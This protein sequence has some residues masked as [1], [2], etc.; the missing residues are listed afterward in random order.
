MTYRCS[1]AIRSCNI[2]RAVEMA[3]V[4]VCR[5][6]ISWSK[7]IGEGLC[8]NTIDSTSEVT[9]GNGSISGLNS[10]HRLTGKNWCLDDPIHQNDSS[11]T[12]MMESKFENAYWPSL[13]SIF[14]VDT[15]K[16]EKERIM[17]KWRFYSMK[18][19]S[20]ATVIDNKN[21]LKLPNNI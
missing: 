8:A 21:L 6:A 12:I 7:F 9:V 18:N 5:F 1:R 3:K 13:F 14:C 2:G 20:W 19:L 16:L 11:L 15:V 10:P 4:L 17:L